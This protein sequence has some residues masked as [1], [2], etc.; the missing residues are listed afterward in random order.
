MPGVGRPGEGSILPP[1]PKSPT[2][3]A[4]TLTEE[5]KHHHV[6]LYL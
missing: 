1:C 5:R 3:R 4:T 2:I 6:H